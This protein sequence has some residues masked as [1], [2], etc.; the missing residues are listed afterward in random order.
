MTNLTAGIAKGAIWSTAATVA[1]LA[2]S[3]LILP[4]LARYLEP[5]DFGVVQM[6]MP[7]IFLFMVLTEAG[8]N[9]ALVRH[10]NPSRAMWT[11]IFW[12]NVGLATCFAVL[13]ALAA[14]LVAAF[15][16]EPDVGPI[17]IGLAAVLVL[18]SL[19]SVPY[20]WLQRKMQFRRLAIIEIVSNVISI[21]VAI[22]AVMMGAKAWAL[23]YQQVAIYATKAV[24]FSVSD[25]PPISFS[26]AADEIRVLM[27]FG[28]SLVGAQLIT[29][30]GNHAANIIIGRMLGAGPLGLYS[31]AYRLT[32]LP[33]QTFS[34]GLSGVFLPALSR[35]RHEPHRLRTACMRMFRILT[36]MV[37]PVFAGLGAL[38]GPFV[39][40]IV[41]ERMA[42][43]IPLVQFLAPVAA[44]QAMIPLYATVY[45]ALGRTD[46]M[47]RWSII[48]NVAF[49]AAYIVGSWFGGIVGVAMAL[50]VAQ[51]LI[52][53][54]A[55]K[56][57]VSLLDGDLT[58]L[59][60]AT[61]INAGGA[62]VMALVVYAISIYVAAQ[63]GSPLMQ[64]IVGIP[65][66]AAF[67]V[68]VLLWLQRD[69]LLEIINLAGAALRPPGAA[70]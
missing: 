63:G 11:S 28:I 8:I 18:Q 48:Q 24:L 16:D 59:A 21:I 38:A 40:V 3:I 66:G 39:L 41:G 20:A 58:D 29:F 26:Y 15:Y 2:S 7:F 1:R 67:Y 25:R 32:V 6:S 49:I 13:L 31:I 30:A 52:L 62:V 19:S 53:L 34:F 12:T 10:D 46:V 43:A 37:F 47:L 23:V 5:R 36:S 17:V 4:V 9:P 56:A 57:M 65:T 42:S 51:L 50:C 69:T 61:A 70:E 45:I 60:K 54:P 68:L 27:R 33:G 14:P 55:S 64:L 22:V 35:L 44:L